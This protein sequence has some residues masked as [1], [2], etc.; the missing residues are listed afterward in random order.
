MKKKIIFIAFVLALCVITAIPAFASE[1]EDYARVEDK[2]S[3][4]SESELEALSLK[5]DEI[6]KRQKLDV[7]IVTVDG[8]DGAYVRDYA[9]D[10]YDYHGF[11][12]GSDHDGI[13][14]LISLE[15]R[16]WCI[17]TCGY[18][19]T[20]FTDAG[21]NYIAD[22]I[23]PELSSGSYASAFTE[24]ADLCDDFI[25]KAHSGESYDNGNLPREPLS[26]AWI[27]ISLL[28][29]FVIAKIVVSGMKNKLKTVRAKV[30]ANSY[31]IDG[32][33]N[34]TE[35]SDLFLYHTVTRT[36][37]EKESSSGSSTHTSSSGTT[38]GGQSGKF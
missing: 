10:Y 11:G 27:V 15:E 7:I 12:Y 19:I 31:V 23:K 22:K 14:L 25:T 24:F 1:N 28:I 36:A 13:L 29:G 18:G 5:L 33:M 4:L 3:L 38:H 17:S 8:L 26:S 6:S 30:E 35:N 37:K 32:S 20:A 21:C 16:D 34:V 9:D 2:A